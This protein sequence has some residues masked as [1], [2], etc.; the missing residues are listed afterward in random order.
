MLTTVRVLHHF[1]EVF[2]LEEEVIEPS[3]YWNN[4]MQ[5]LSDEVLPHRMQ[6]YCAWNTY[7]DRILNGWLFFAPN[8]IFRLKNEDSFLI[9]QQKDK[10]LIYNCV[11]SK[12]HIMVS[13]QL[14]ETLNDIMDIND[15]FN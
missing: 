12:L 10:W 7:S 3:S 14:E 13:G 1:T 15:N 11:D 2:K 5:M 4:D 9:A 8:H 6:L